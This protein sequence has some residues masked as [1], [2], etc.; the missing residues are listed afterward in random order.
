MDRQ[1]GHLWVTQSRQG[2]WLGVPG[3][4]VPSSLH[5]CVHA[6]TSQFTFSGLFDRVTRK[7][8]KS[9]LL[10]SRGEAPAVSKSGR[11]PSAPGPAQ[12]RLPAKPPGTRAGCTPLYVYLL[13]LIYPTQTNWHPL[14]HHIAF[15]TGDLCTRPPARPGLHVR[16]AQ[17]RECFSVHPAISSWPRVLPGVRPGGRGKISLP[18]ITKLRALSWNNFS[19]LFHSSGVQL[20]RGEKYFPGHTTCI[21]KKV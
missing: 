15:S 10:T 2:G 9:V 20:T 3:R 19:C 1:Q 17:C 14:T 5:R 4:L 16:G 11:F 12:E 13:L 21:F 18:F 7:C 6:F 8:S